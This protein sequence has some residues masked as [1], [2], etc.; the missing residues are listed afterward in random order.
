MS[1]LLLFSCATSAAFF[2]YVGGV[3]V[4]NL[5]SLLFIDRDILAIQQIITHEEHL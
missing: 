1:Q 5:F 2:S 3:L 4:A